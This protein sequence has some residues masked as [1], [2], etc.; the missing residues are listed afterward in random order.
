MADEI[1]DLKQRHKGDISTLWK[2]YNVDKPFYDNFYFK[3]SFATTIVALL[4]VFVLKSDIYN[5]ICFISEISVGALPTLLGFNLGAY[6]LI[7]GFG[8]SDILAII[9]KPLEGQNNYSFYQKLNSVLGVSVV[10]QIITLFL[11]FIIKV[12]KEIQ[13]DYY[14]NIKCIIFPVILNIITFFF[15]MFLVTYSF[16]LL[17]NVVKH[18]FLFAQTIHFFIYKKE[19]DKNKKT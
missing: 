17:I 15:V 5:L 10:V 18:V 1:E 7:V 4:V 3:F 12:W 9:T 16:L 14:W 8:S 19:V 6:I 11:T 13:V 2:I